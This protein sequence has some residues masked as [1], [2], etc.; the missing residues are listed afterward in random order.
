M[1]R[2]FV[3]LRSQRV[4]DGPLTV[5]FLLVLRSTGL[6]VEFERG[7]E[8]PCGSFGLLELGEGP[9]E[10]QCRRHWSSPEPDREC[11]LESLLGELGGVR[12]AVLEVRYV[13]EVLP[14]DDGV[15][16]SLLGGPGTGGTDTLYF[17]G[18]HT[19]GS[20]SGTLG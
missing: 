20:Y 13:G 10:L 7:A 12:V 2:A 4:A 16:G 18:A 19:A 17:A 3:Q 1:K 9:S 15:F 8:Y 6:P 11:L 14:H 5:G